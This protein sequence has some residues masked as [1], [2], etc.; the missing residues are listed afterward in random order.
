MAIIE[1]KQIIYLLKNEIGDQLFTYKS[2]MGIHLNMCK[3]MIDIN[4]YCYYSSTWK[5]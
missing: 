3:Q 1:C 2:Y 5:H 4:C